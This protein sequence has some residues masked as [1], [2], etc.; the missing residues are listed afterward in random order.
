M[1]QASVLAA[2]TLAMGL[3]LAGLS[4]YPRWAFLSATGVLSLAALLGPIAVGD[5]EAW[6]ASASPMLWMHP[7]WPMVMAWVPARGR[8][9]VCATD[10]PGAGWLLIGGAVLVALLSYVSA[11]I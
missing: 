2:G 10:A 8:R 9:G 4:P 5:P 6:R 1:L 3:L 11:W 7:W